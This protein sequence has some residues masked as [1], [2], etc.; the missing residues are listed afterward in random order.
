MTTKK[1]DK[2][3]IRIPQEQ[4]AKFKSICDK[5]GVSMSTLIKLWIDEYIK[6]RK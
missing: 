2:I 3:D 5:N 4:K 6:E 1:I